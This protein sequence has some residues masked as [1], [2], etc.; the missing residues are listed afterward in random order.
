MIEFRPVWADVDLDRLWHNVKVAQAHIGKKQIIPV[1]KANAYGHGALE[2]MTFL[3]EKGIRYC[4]VVMLQEALELR[5]AFP[6]LGILIM[7][8]IRPQDL[9]LCSHHQFDITVYHKPLLEAVKAFKGPLQCHLKVD[10]GMARY[11]FVETA[12]IL[13]AAKTLMTSSHIEWTGVFTHFATADQDADFVN[14][15]ITR[16]IEVLKQLPELPPMI[17]VANSAGTFRFEPDIPMTTHVRLGLSLYGCVNMPLPKP[18][19]KQV[20]RLRGAISQIKP[21]KKGEC[22]GY[23]QTYCAG[24]D[25]IIA[26]VPIGYADGIRRAYRDHQVAIKGRIYPMVGAICMDALFIK[27]DDSVGL[28]DVVDIYGDVVTIDDAAVHL[29]TTAYEIMTAISPRVPRRYVKGESG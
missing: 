22:L 18:P 3:Y 2:V 28:E 14:Q 10:T 11:G 26:L 17:H 8:S 1:V 15:Q 29:G 12:D 4:A 13:D 9:E 19:V 5:N 23:G 25:E 24:Q 7:G 6:D 16:F 20:A 27:V 21:L